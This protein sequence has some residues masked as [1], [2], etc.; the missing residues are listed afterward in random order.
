MEVRVKH[1][2]ESECP[3]VMAGIEIELYKQHYFT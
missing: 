2:G 1:G 3:A